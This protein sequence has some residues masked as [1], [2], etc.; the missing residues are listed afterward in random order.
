ME[1]DNLIEEVQQ[2]IAQFEHDR[3]TANATLKQL[4]EQL[5]DLCAQV[6]HEFEDGHCIICFHY[7]DREPI[8]HRE[9]LNFLEK[10]L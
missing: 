3:D 9:D 2:A 6:G 5:Q 8:D 1:L 10:G 4:R 7:D